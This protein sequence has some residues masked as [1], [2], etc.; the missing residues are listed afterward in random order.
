MSNNVIK[1]F[2]IRYT[3]EKKLIDISNRETALENANEAFSGGFVSGIAAK[4]LSETSPQEGDLS[5]ISAE[6]PEPEAFTNLPEASSASEPS[7]P[8]LERYR[9]SL[10]GELLEELSAQIQEEKEAALR[11]AREEAE[12]ILSDARAEAEALKQQITA[13]AQ[14]EGYRQGQDRLAQEEARLKQEFETKT[15]ELTDALEQKEKELEPKACEVVAGLV[16]SLTG[17]L[18]EEKKGIVSYLVTRALSEADPSAHF[19]IKVSAEDYN[20]VKQQSKQFYE[21]FDREVTIEIAQDVLL[22]KGE[23]MIETD[24]NVMD[25]SLGTRLQGL[26]S[27]L[28]MMALSD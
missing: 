27:D 3:E 11:E 16:S 24:S 15:K 4:V 28:R 22:K 18:L 25:C 23:C 17:V 26:L 6:S 19:L 8:N 10:R 20:E 12:R 5:E 13:Q 1:A 9:E 2:T 21:L 14:T 7:A